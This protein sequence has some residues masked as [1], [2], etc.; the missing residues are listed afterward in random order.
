[1]ATDG[2]KSCR[3][4]ITNSATRLFKSKNLGVIHPVGLQVLSWVEY[5][6]EN[7]HFGANIPDEFCWTPQGTINKKKTAEV[8]VKD[9]RV[10]VMLHY[11]LACSYCVENDIVK[12]WSEIPEDRKKRY[13][14]NKE[15]PEKVLH[16]TLVL[17]CTYDMEGEI[18]KLDNFAQSRLKRR[19]SPYRWAFEY[20]AECGNKAA[21]EYFL[22]KLRTNEREECLIAAAGIVAMRRFHSPRKFLFFPKNHYIEALCFLLSQMGDEQ[23][24]EVFK[25]NPSQL[26]G[27]FLDW[28]WQSLFL[29]TASRMFHLLTEENYHSL[30]KIIVAR[31]LDSSKDY[32]YQNLFREFWNESPD[33][34]KKSYIRICV[35]DS[36]LLKELLKIDDKENVKLI[37]GSATLKEKKEILY[38]DEGMEICKYLHD[39]KKSDL[40]K[41][42]VQECDSSKDAMIKFNKMF[43]RFV[44]CSQEKEEEERHIAAI[45][46]Q[47]RKDKL[48]KE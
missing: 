24:A 9:E 13:Y 7:P 8:C 17:C 28:P 26:L 10:N 18:S 20:A 44:L 30:L 32:N 2:R 47:F 23:Q 22:E 33:T 46:E 40:L 34:H 37:L 45:F 21:L 41:F 39:R 12:L 29:E 1:M 4:G 14:Y 43:R 36:T 42:F 27:C 48:N 38:S 11:H 31:V 35:S 3:K 5:H 25:K 19:C 6:N 16:D 15:D